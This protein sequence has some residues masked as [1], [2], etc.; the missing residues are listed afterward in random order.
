MTKLNKI[1]VEEDFFNTLN[2]LKKCKINLPD[3]ASNISQDMQDFVFPPNG[4]LVCDP[5]KLTTFKLNPMNKDCSMNKYKIFS[6]DETVRKYVTLQ[7]SAYLTTHSIVKLTEKDYEPVTLSKFYF[8]TRIR[9][10]VDADKNIIFSES[11]DS[12]SKKNYVKDKVD[13]LLKNVEN[14]TILF[15][16]GP[17]IG[18]DW[19]V[20]MIKA[21]NEFHKRNIIPIFMV[22]NS[23]SDLITK[24]IPK[25]K[26]E[27]NSDMH[28]SFDFLK[29]SERTN[30]FTYRDAHNHQNAKVFCYFKPFNCSPQRLEFH[31][32]TYNKFK[33]EIDNFLDL[34]QYLMLVN[35]DEK[36][37]QIRTIAIAEFFARKVQ[38]LFDLNN[39]MRSTN[40]TPSVN[41]ER[42]AW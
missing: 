16:D 2:Q 27:Y 28:W 36:S 6:Y 8:Y 23:S 9:S 39:I 15:I 22:K 19:Y 12:D 30:F 5:D 11:P 21:I 34:V 3:S 20:Y 17:L 40:F 1:M 4:E 42:F 33:D 14:N 26:K 35:G 10:L 37:P 7:G 13:F 18:G 25:L 32:D 24:N 29:I 31:I 38:N 41:Q